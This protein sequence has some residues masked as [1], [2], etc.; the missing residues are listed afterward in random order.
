MFCP[1]SSHT[2]TAHQGEDCGEGEER[3]E[4]ESEGAGAEEKA[5]GS[6]GGRVVVGDGGG[7]GITPA[8]AGVAGVNESWIWRG[9][10]VVVGVESRCFIDESKDSSK[11]LLR[12]PV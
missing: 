4:G 9:R 1:P 10:V 12:R 6:L 8:E 3:G 11:S 5:G 7:G 2:A